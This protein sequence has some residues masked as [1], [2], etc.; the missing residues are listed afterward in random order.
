MLHLFLV[1]LIS[2]HLFIHA[3]LADGVTPNEAKQ[4]RDEVLSL[5][6]FSVKFTSVSSSPPIYSVYILM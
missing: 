4:L 2:S 5:A 1:S 6:L 3:A